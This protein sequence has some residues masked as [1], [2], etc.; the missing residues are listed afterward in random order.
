MAPI[1]SSTPTITP[2]A[3]ATS[4]PTPD[5]ATAYDARSGAFIKTAQGKTYQWIPIQINSND[6]AAGHWF[7]S[8]I[9][10]LKSM[11]LLD[12]AANPY[13]PA[14]SLPSMLPMQLYFIEDLR[15][16]TSVGY[17]YH[18]DAREY[19]AKRPGNEDA[20]LAKGCSLTAQITRALARRVAGRACAKRVCEPTSDEQASTLKALAAGSLILPFDV[21]TDAGA[22]PG[23]APRSEYEWNVSKGYR[24]YVINWEDADTA[25]DPA[26]AESEAGYARFRWKITVRDG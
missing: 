11:P 16:L 4:V 26:F 22:K 23:S 18:P 13:N 6:S 5:G 12:A 20:W 24:V 21:S 15:Q 19:Y 1:Q 17:L 3:T 8:R 25:L 14:P 2:T 7:E 10:G 9:A